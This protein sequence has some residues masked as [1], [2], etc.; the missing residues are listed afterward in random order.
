MLLKGK[1]LYPNTTSIGEWIASQLSAYPNRT[2]MVR[3]QQFAAMAITDDYGSNDI[4][5]IDTTV[6]ASPYMG[7][8]AG[9][10][11]HGL[12]LENVR[13]T[14][15]QG[16]PFSTIADGAHFTGVGGDIIVEGGEFEREGDDVMNITEVW[17]TLTAV[18]SSD[19][20]VMNGA[21]AIPSEGD[22]I[23][24]FD[25]AMGFLGSAEVESISPANLPPWAGQPI[26]VQLKSQLSWLKPGIHAINMN[27]APSRVY[28]SD[29]DIHDKL[30]RGILLG[31]F[32]ILVRRSTFRNM[33]A[34]AIASILSSYFGE[35]TGASDVAIRDNQI[36][37]TNYVA[38]LFQSSNDGTNTY[39]NRNASIAM[40]GDIFSSYDGVSNEVTA[41]YPLYQDIE[42]SGNEIESRTGAGIFLSGTKNVHI[43]QDRF[44]GC[45]AVP[46]ADPLYSYYGSESTSAVVLSFADTVFAKGDRTTV[47]PSCFARADASSSK[48]V[49]VER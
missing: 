19:S 48:D 41:V 21:D 31:G 25:E 29:V 26:T 16:R 43:D 30:G 45:G 28:V 8:T 15:S 36:T 2:V 37:G 23:A 7:I 39:P 27:H 49:V 9:Q 20:F 47:D 5:I 14:P 22:T 35:S 18:N 4:R 32:H 42:I 11:G 1:S 24:F 3:F 34:S 40:F 6:H 10:G 33:T 44:T 13:E 12:A 46:D 17:D 38:K